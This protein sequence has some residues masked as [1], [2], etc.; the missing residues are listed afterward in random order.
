M[1]TKKTLHNDYR[2]AERVLAHGIG[3]FAADRPA[4]PCTDGS[5]YRSA[6][7]HTARLAVDENPS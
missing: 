6:A 2:A 1:E 3:Y 4:V 7:T 5:H